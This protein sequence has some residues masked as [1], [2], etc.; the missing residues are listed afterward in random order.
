[1]YIPLF[2]LTLAL[3]GQNPAAC[4]TVAPPAPPQ[5]DQL[6]SLRTMQD[7][8]G[9]TVLADGTKAP[10]NLVL[11][12]LTNRRQ[13]LDFMRVH[14]PDVKKR[15]H[16]DVRPIAWICVDRRGHVARATL[17]NASGEDAFD[18]LSLNVFTV[19]A[20]TPA[21]VGTDTVA[22]W[23]PLP[24]VVPAKEEL[25]Y[26]LA[27]EGGDHS[28]QPSRTPFDEAPQ[29]MN[30]SRIESAILRVIYNVNRD[31]VQKA[32]TMYRSQQIGGEAIMWIYIDP[33]GAVK[34]SILKKTSGNADLD[35]S[36]QQIVQQMQFMPAKLKG[37]A[38]EAWI[39]VP[40]AFR[41]RQ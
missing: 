39:E 10:E 11:P 36:A 18:A 16:G 37:K 17:I 1:M 20:F 5:A 9:V 21:Q 6:A 33:T 13:T 41:A 26:A 40:I 30:R 35:V 23:L 4:D 2:L 34:N 25:E 28:V 22:V 32:E 3:A 29:L 38:V 19:A 8:I 12:K 14:Y 31:A 15:K 24:A 27:A 7:V